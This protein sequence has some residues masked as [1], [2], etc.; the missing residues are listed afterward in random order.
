MLARAPPSNPMPSTLHGLLDALVARA[1][2][3]MLLGLDR[4]EAALAALGDPHLGLAAVHVAGSNGKG[5][6]A[7]MVESIARAAGLRTGLYTSP[8]LCRF[9]ERIRIDGRSIE[10]DAFERSLV[11]VLDR[12]R[13]DLTFFESLTVAAFFAFREAAVDVAVVEV[14]LGGRLDATN[15]IEAP[16]AAAITSI[17]L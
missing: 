1:P 12:C 10:D 4:V 3:G 13:P 5:S 9:A 14:G 8:H 15:V 16:I 7:A 6:T 11:A 17:S 2:R